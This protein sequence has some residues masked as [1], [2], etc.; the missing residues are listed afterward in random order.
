[1]PADS[2][3]RETDFQRQ[4]RQFADHI[5]QP[6]QHPAPADVEARR[7]AIYNELFYNNVDS[8]LAGSFPVLRRITPAA[9]WHAL[10]RDFLANH[11]CCTPLFT[12]LAEEFL[13][14]LEHE[15][16]AREQDYPFL[17]ELA[18]YEWVE[19]AL[20][21][22]DAD[23]ALP[24]LDPNGD[25]LSG[26]PVISPLAWPLS[27]RFPVHRIGPD[28]LPAEPPSSPTYL[29]VYRD[30]HDKVGFLEINPV[31][32]ALLEAL[33]NDPALSG[34]AALESIAAVLNHPN[35]S[36]V[37]EAGTDLLH[38]LRRREILLGT[39]A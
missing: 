18:H 17:L 16:G 13:D 10:M 38:D 1:M 39:A 14:Y 4:Q 25:L 3:S 31:T 7:M 29:V 11:A 8:F 22:S 24:P 15:R 36:T 33:D 35:P 30:R 20:T 2:R 5:R 34:L 26:H 32:H 28:D 23:Q 21:L 19:L 9:Q 12:R 37:V 27:Y 6:D